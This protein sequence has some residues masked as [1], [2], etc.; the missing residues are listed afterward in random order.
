MTN[1]VSLQLNSLHLKKLCPDQASRNVFFS[2]GA[3]PT[4]PRLSPKFCL[5]CSGRLSLCRTLQNQTWLNIQDGGV[6]GGSLLQ[7]LLVGNF[8]NFLN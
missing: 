7:P 1:D 2:N 3:A 6:Q 5:L 4:V 8:T